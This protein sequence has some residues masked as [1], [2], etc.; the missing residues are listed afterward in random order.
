[1]PRARILSEFL[2]SSQ[3]NYESDVMR[4]QQRRYPVRRP[5]VWSRL[6]SIRQSD[7]SEQIDGALNV[8]YPNQQPPTLPTSCHRRN[9]SQGQNRSQQ[10][11]KCCRIC[12]AWWN[13]GIGGSRSQKHQ[14]QV[15][16]GMQQKDWEQDS[17]RL[18]LI[19]FRD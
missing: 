9:R 16:Q 14:S 19:E 1:M 3:E 12:K 4:Y 10:I 5:H 15:P 6:I 17:S 2:S 11:A 7:R 8:E 18:Q 13:T